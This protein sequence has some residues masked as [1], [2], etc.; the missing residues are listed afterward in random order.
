MPRRERPDRDRAYVEDIL[1]SAQAMAAY[2]S[3][4]TAES[5]A[6][7]RML[8]DA[9]LRRLT[10]IGECAACLSQVYKTSHAQAAW[11]EIVALRNLLVHHYWV[12]DDERIW[13]YATVDVPEFAAYLAQQ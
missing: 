12:I 1:D 4:Q 8:V 5:F 13:M 7:N 6:A 9:V 2:V 11:K 3:H 10:I